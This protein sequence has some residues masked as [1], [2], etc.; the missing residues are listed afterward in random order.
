[1]KEIKAGAHEDAGSQ[2]VITTSTATNVA[3]KRVIVTIHAETNEAGCCVRCGKSC[4]KG[5]PFETISE[6]YQVPAVAFLHHQPRSRFQFN[7]FPFSPN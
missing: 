2:G 6:A 7:C 5:F 3:K 1:M 4:P